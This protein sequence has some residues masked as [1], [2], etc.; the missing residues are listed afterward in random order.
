M[1]LL[2]VI[3]LYDLDGFDKRSSKEDNPLEFYGLRLYTINKTHIL[4]N[5]GF[6]FF[7]KTDYVKL[8]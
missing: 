6:M 8:E 1:T 3:D 7:K 4:I 5:V 2:Y